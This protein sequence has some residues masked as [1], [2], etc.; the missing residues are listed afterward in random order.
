M[1]NDNPHIGKDGQYPEDFKRHIVALR[2]SGRKCKELCK[3]YGLGKNTIT[4]WV[5]ELTGSEEKQKIR[6]L[7]KKVKQL[8]MQ[9]DILRCLALLPDE[10]KKR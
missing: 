4:E 2:Q 1:S 9:V 5:K 6:A 7:E 8:E 3:E 10:K